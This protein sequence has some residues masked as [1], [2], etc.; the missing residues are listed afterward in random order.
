M[1][2]KLGMTRVF[3]EKEGKSIPVTIIKAGPCW[4]TQVKTKKRDG[5]NAIQIGFGKTKKISKPLKGHLKKIKSEVDGLPYFRY[6]KEFKTDHP[7][8]YKPGQKLDVTQF[9]EGS[10]VTVTGTTKSKGFQGVVKRHGFKGGPATHGTKHTHRTPGSIGS[11]F[12]ERVWKGKKM[13]GRM[14]GKKK[15]IPNLEVVACDADKNLMA[16]KG[17][18]PG[19]K[20]SLISIK[21]S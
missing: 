3:S 18:V 21:Q 9:K 12:P 8:Q 2:E 5:Y 7:S 15:T 4:V 11:A 16:L 10:K 20:G 6:L 17:A 19:N 14:G 13:P 1:G